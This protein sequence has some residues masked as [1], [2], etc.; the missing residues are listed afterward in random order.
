MPKKINIMDPA[1]DPDAGLDKVMHTNWTH[2]NVDI[3]ILTKRS[4]DK[5]D[6]G[7]ISTHRPFKT[8]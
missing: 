2:G 3:K 1:D 8:G 4:L 5:A 6:V 7:V